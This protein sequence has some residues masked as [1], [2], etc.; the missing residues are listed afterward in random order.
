M[1]TYDRF[2]DVFF[3]LVMR[4]ATMAKI[5]TRMPIVTPMISDLFPEVSDGVV[6]LSVTLYVCD[7][8]LLRAT[9]QCSPLSSVVILAQL[10]VELLP[11]EARV[12]LLEW[13]LLSAVGRHAAP[14]YQ[15]YVWTG[16]LA[17][18]LQVRVTGC[19]S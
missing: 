5:A 10:S 16:G 15:V 2:L 1:R 14:W 9:Q 3:L 8:C 11:V 13:K 19:P 18:L 12:C 17:S 4:K 6:P 7:P